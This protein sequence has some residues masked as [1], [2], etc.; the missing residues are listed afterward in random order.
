MVLNAMKWMLALGLL[1]VSGCNEQL[2]GAQVGN[3]AI[4]NSS[5][6]D[7]SVNDLNKVVAC[8]RD[9]DNSVLNIELTDANEVA[10]LKLRITGFRPNPQPYT[11]RQAPDN[12]SAGS[13][14]SKFETCFVTGRVPASST[15]SE[16]NGYSMY[17]DEAEKSQSLVYEGSCVID[18]LDVASYV[19]GTVKCTRMIQT[20]LSG[21]PRNPIDASVTADVKATFNCPLE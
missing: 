4:E 17:R 18:V 11:C 3:L 15:G 5:S 8:K 20:Y 1:Q 12:R 21:A 10:N 19:K 13:L 14:G 9:V 7:S 6:A 2:P 16:V